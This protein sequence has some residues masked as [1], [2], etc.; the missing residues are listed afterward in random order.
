MPAD[1]KMM[2]AGTTLSY[3]T[4]SGGTY[5]VLAAVKSI[6]PPSPKRAEAD[7]T[8]LDSPN[9]TRE[10][11]PSWANSGDCS[12]TAYFG[13][14]QFAALLGFFTAATL[15]YWKVTFPMVGAE[16]AGSVFPFSGYVTEV[17]FD[18]IS[19]DDQGIVMCP[20][21]IAVTGLPTFTPGA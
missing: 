16:A 7:A 19:T 20:F 1:P 18:Q 2:G 11:M 14:T 4:T 9:M 13:K 6:T 15:L 8:A 17:G 21:K 5:T 10:K 12:F 3:S